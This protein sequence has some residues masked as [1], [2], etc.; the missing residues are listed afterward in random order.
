[1]QLRPFSF[2]AHKDFKIIP[3]SHLLTWAYLMKV[4][5]VTLMDI[6]LRHSKHQPISPIP[7]RPFGFLAT[8][9]FQII[10]LSHLLTW[11][12]LM[13]V[14][15]V[16]IMD[17]CLRHS[18]HQPISPIPRRPFGFLATKL[19]TFNYTIIIK[20]Y[21]YC[22]LQWNSTCEGKN[23]ENY[24]KNTPKVQKI[25]WFIFNKRYINIS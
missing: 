18:K 24:F 16:T 20:N 25:Y 4:T 15:P 14:T 21:D 22:T 1:M 6:C 17:I 12:Y 2:L 11:A 8:K 3:L 19:R 10:P 23:H 13:K 9:D 7:R 5:P